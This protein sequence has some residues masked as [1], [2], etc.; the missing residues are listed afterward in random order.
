MR[1]AVLNQINKPS[2]SNKG[3]Y[4]TVNFCRYC[5]RKTSI[6]LDLYSKKENICVNR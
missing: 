4:F 5:F 6:H 1:I 3:L 2:R